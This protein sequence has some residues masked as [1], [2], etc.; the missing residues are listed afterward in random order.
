MYVS[1]NICF[2]PAKVVIVNQGEKAC[3]WYEFEPGHGILQD[4]IYDS[5]D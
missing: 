2:N 5:E 4:C 3:R 1:I